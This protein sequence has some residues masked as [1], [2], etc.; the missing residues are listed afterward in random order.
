MENKYE[1]VYDNYDS[2]NYIK[3]K[4]WF[5]PKF[6]IVNILYREECYMKS[7]GIQDFTSM[8]ETKGFEKWII[9]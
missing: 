4:L 7:V 6:I 5:I 8:N 2:V 9:K 3:K 1:R